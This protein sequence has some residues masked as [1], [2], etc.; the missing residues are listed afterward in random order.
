MVSNQ[1]LQQQLLEQKKVEFKMQECLRLMECQLVHL[2]ID[3]VRMLCQ[4]LHQVEDILQSTSLSSVTK[5]LAEILFQIIRATRNEEEIMYACHA[6]EGLIAR[7]LLGDRES[8][9]EC[10]QV[11]HQLLNSDRIL[12]KVKI[13][14]VETIQLMISLDDQAADDILDLRAIHQV[15]NA[16]STSDR[17]FHSIIETLYIYMSYNNSSSSLSSVQQK[18][19]VNNESRRAKIQAEFGREF[20]DFLQFKTTDSQDSLLDYTSTVSAFKSLVKQKQ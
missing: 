18:L 11:L 14:V 15:I 5:S 7:Q 17:L 19:N 10:S 3:G 9:A 12:E 8:T 1:L 20:I 16:Q 6:L 2:R 13:S 4:L